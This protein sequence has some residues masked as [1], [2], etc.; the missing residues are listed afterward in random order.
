MTSFIL[1]KSFFEHYLFTLLSSTTGNITVHQQVAHSP[2]KPE[3]HAHGVVWLLFTLRPSLSC[4]ICAGPE[5]QITFSPN[6]LKHGQ[7]SQALANCCPGSGANTCT[8]LLVRSVHHRL[9]LHAR[10]PEE[11]LIDRAQTVTSPPIEPC[12][13]DENKQSFT[14]TQ[15]VQ[16]AFIKEGLAREI[17]C[18][19]SAFNKIRQA[20]VMTSR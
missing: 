2:Q 12:C 20:S 1:H 16:S 15:R 11:P 7:L 13:T 8:S 3:P 17:F 14:R 5:R 4:Q 19:Q 6:T 10:E 18:F 9:G